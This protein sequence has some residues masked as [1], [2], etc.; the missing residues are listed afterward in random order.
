MKIKDVIAYL[1]QFTPDEECAFDLWTKEDLDRL[2]EIEFPLVKF[3]P[4]EYTKVFNEIEEREDTS[5]NS[6]KKVIEDLL[7]GEL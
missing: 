6:A 5:W 3:S 4:H 2:L 1:Y 7:D